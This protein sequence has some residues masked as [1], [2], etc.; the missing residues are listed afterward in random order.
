MTKEDIEWLII[1]LLAEDNARDAA[2]L[3]QELTAAGAN[4]PVDSLLAAEVLAR[5]Q[6]QCEVELP[7]SAETARA[8]RSVKTFAQAVWDLLPKEQSKA[9]TA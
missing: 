6:E 8:L 5:V 2:D 4:M 3:L 1:E 9:A 7:T